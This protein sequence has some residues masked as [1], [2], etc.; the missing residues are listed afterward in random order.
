MCENFLYGF[1]A[2]P[3]GGLR[4]GNH[5]TVTGNRPHPPHQASDGRHA[6]RACLMEQYDYQARPPVITT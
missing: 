6:G 2:G 1:K 5:T 3:A 4:P